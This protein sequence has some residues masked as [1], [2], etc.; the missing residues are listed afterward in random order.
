M[1]SAYILYTS[2][3][4][5]CSTYSNAEA[6]LRDNFVDFPRDCMNNEQHAVNA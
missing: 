1:R 4:N 3:S 5:P 2:T 6:E